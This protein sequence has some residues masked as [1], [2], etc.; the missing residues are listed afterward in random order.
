M[1][2]CVVAAA[3]LSVGGETLTWVLWAGTAILGVSLA[4]VFPTLLSWTNEHV[5][6]SVSEPSLA[7]S[8][9]VLTVQGMIAVT[10]SR[11]GRVYI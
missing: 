6:V 5:E 4:P 7:L 10:L 11:Y 3:A 2:L 8:G 1:V 9:T